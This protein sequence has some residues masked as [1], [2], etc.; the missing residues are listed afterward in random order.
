MTEKELRQ[1]RNL[2]REIEQDYGT[3]RALECASA[4]GAQ[5]FTALPRVPGITDREADYAAEIDALKQVIGERYRRCL[6]E[7]LRLEHFINSVEDSVIRQAMQLRYVRGLPWEAVAVQM[8]SVNS[9]EN[10]RQMVHRYL[11][12]QPE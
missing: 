9:P 10:L 7:R 2:K 11:K 4:P 6:H 8:G 3:V 12:R 5:R 1:Y